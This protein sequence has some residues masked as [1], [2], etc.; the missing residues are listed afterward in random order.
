MAALSALGNSVR[1]ERIAGLSCSRPFIERWVLSTLDILGGLLIPAVGGQVD[2]SPFGPPVLQ[3]HT[4][5]LSRTLSCRPVGRSWP[6]E[7]KSRRET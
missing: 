1:S 7:P 4:H 2:A 3:G 5:H 6:N